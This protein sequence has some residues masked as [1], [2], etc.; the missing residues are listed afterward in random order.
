MTTQDW[1]IAGLSFGGGFLVAMVCFSWW[2][3]FAGKSDMST[4]PQN[5]KEALSMVEKVSKLET[6]ASVSVSD[7][8]AGRAVM[9]S[10]IRLD[11]PAWIAVRE[12]VNDSPTRILGAVLRDTGDHADV[13]VDL[14][15][16][17]EPDREYVIS[18]YKDNGDNVFD[19]KK[20]TLVEWATEDSA[21]ARFSAQTPRSPAGR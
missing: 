9:V 1:K 5:N 21:A 7:Q 17:T 15:R 16:T 13:T 14:L 12:L 18:L 2:S 20:D 10:R 4:T 19:S 6:E 3:S 8:P 11:V